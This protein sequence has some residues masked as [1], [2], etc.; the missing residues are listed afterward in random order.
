[1]LNQ[2]AP[3]FL[4]LGGVLFRENVRYATVSCECCSVD[5]RTSCLKNSSAINDGSRPR[6]AVE[7]RERLGE[8]SKFHQYAD[9][10]QQRF[11]VFYIVIG[12]ILQ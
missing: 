1:M 10:E 11:R 7:H 2:R 8:F 9:V 12:N 3:R 6:V 5:I 4:C